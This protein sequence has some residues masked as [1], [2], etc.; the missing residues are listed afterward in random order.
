M[1]PVEI[2][3]G[4]AV[5]WLAGMALCLADVSAL[6]WAQVR[7]PFCVRCRVLLI[8][9]TSTMISGSPPVME[10]IYECPRGATALE[11]RMVGA[12]D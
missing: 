10:T 9:A 4:E 8:A 6:F 12:W 5:R 2:V 11:E 1:A 3:D 7:A